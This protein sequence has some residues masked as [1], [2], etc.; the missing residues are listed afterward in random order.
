MGMSGADVVELC[1]SVYQWSAHAAAVRVQ[2]DKKVVESIFE[3]GG[4]GSTQ[5]SVAGSIDGVQAPPS[6]PGVALRGPRD[7]IT[8]P[9]P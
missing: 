7:R 3:D 4:N 8:W 6:A 9:W 1:C 2:V 5:Q